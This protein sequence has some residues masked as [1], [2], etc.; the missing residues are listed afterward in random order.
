[1][2]RSALLP[3]LHIARGLTQEDAVRAALCGQEAGLKKMQKNI[4]TAHLMLYGGGGRR[5][6]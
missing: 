4:F 2:R 6:K 5:R 1:M 3:Q